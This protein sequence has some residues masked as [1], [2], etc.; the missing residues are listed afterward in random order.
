MSLSSQIK[1]ISSK[2]L[3]IGTSF[4]IVNFGM[5]FLAKKQGDAVR[6]FYE[7]LPSDQQKVLYDNCV[8]NKCPITLDVFG[9]L[10]RDAAV[11]T[12][13]LEK[14]PPLTPYN[15]ISRKKS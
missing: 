5:F 13:S 2:Q 12:G 15:E 6:A 4:F 8:D 11:R 1:K 7:N 14:C 10:L 9:A 3:A